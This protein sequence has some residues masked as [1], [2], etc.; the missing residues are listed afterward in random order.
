MNSPGAFQ[1]G[2]FVLDSGARESV[3]PLKS[4]FSIPY[5]SMFFLDVILIGFQSQAFWGLVS[6]MQ[7]LR[8]GVL[9]IEHRPPHSLEKS[10][11][12]LRSLPIVG[13]CTRVEIFFLVRLCFCIS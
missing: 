8:F 1:T 2:V 13:R 5:R 6:P 12:F 7:D 9:A 4:R 3:S 11:V 10:S